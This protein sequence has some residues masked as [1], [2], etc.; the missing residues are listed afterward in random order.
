MHLFG[1]PG[2]VHG[3]DAEIL[4]LQPKRAAVLAYL[5]VSRPGP[6][7]RRDRL[8]A[9]FWPEHSTRRGRNALSK[10]VHHLGRSLP[11]GS[12]LTQ[13]DQIGIAPDRLWCDVRAFEQALDSGRAEEALSLYGADL[14]EG[15]HIAG[16]PDFDQWA[17]AERRRLRRQAVASAWELASEA[18]Q[19]GDGPRAT[20]FARRAVEW[21][22]RDESAF[23]RFLTLLHNRGNR[24]EALEAFDRF[25]RDLLRD[26]GVEPSAPTL[27]L[28]EAIRDG[29][30]HTEPLPSI[31]A[32]LT[33]G[34]RTFGSH[35]LEPSSERKAQEGEL[36]PTLPVPVPGPTQKGATPRR[37]ITGKL[38]WGVV[39]MAALVLSGSEPL[40]TSG[41]EVPAGSVL[42][43]EFED[44]TD[45]GTDQ[46]P[47]EGLGPAVS[48]A[49]RIDLA[50]SRAFHLVDP[51]DIGETLEF[52]GRRRSAA[53]SAEVGHEVAARS[54]IDAVVEGAVL[55]AGTGYILTAAIRAGSDGRTIASLRESVTD[56]DQMIEGIDHL[57]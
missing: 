41:G 2:L 6:L 36:T 29:T 53:V 32:G 48:E 45:R 40:P 31:S 16:S 8:L 47:D 7:H 26:Y 55:R 57:S 52:M 50:Q 35:G 4:P 12:I 18:E 33:P 46:S 5:V 43:T 51:V 30:L 11:P 23:C 20:A 22:P 44:G 34:G 3:P 13:D 10:V 25:A 21:A 15:F 14:L 28:I 37:P 39:G 49:L 56:P 19:A 9:I 42:V 38:A 54:G 17:D 27:E 24:G 1:A